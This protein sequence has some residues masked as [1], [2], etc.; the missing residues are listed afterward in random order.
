MSQIPDRKGLVFDEWIRV[1]GG[2]LLVQFILPD[3]DS[4]YST[5]V[6]QVVLAHAQDFRPDHK[7]AFEKS[8]ALNFE[9]LSN[10]HIDFVPNPAD[11]AG[12]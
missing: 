5:Q 1:A 2:K 3:R 10:L 6:G 7:I 11:T 9:G 4:S 8:L 12:T